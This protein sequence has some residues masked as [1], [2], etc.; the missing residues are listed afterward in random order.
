[1]NASGSEDAEATP[2]GSGA[3]APA[4]AAVL[5]VSASPFYVTMSYVTL[6]YVAL[7]CLVREPELMRVKLRF[8]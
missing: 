6:F 5:P 1:M 7:S 4:S 3:R 8:W 2:T